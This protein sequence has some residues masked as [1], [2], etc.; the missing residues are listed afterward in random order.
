MGKIR[1]TDTAD[2]IRILTRQLLVYEMKY[3]ENKVHHLYTKGLENNIIFRDREDYTVGMNYIALC[4]FICGIDLLAFTLMSNHFHF[5]ALGKSDDCKRFIDLFKFHISRYIRHKYG[6]ESLL[7][8]IDTH[9]KSIENTNDALRTLIAYI[10]RNHIKAGINQ[11]IQG[12]EWSSGRCYFSGIDHLAGTIPVTRLGTREYR[13][14][15]RT[16]TVVKSSF[17]LNCKGYIEP[18]SYIRT[19]IVESCFGRPQSLD[20]HV[21]KIS[22]QRSKEG[23]VEF[24]DGLVMA[25][26]K[27]ILVKKYDVDRIEALNESARKDVALLLKRQ[28]NS[29]PKQL[30]RIIQISL[31]ELQMWLS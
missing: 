29:P 17:M 15:M 3:N 26:L 6:T 30:A 16:R 14:I 7:R 4:I 12:Y 10:L 23:P 5:A 13:R 18:A 9:C 31:S 22:S 21:F 2:N 24:S 8:R 19:D 28:F 27:E 20:Y 1:T 11:T 25:G